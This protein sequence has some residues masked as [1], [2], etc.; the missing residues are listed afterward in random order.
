MS[1]RG[2]SRGRARVKGGWRLW[3][4][5]SPSHSTILGFVIRVPE[6]CLVREVALDPLA[7]L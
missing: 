6:V 2:A 5:V 3:K 4:E 7:V 1:D